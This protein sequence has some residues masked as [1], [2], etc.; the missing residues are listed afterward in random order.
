MRAS[1]ECKRGRHQ[2]A[3][4]LHHG[5]QVCSGQLAAR[6]P[7]KAGQVASHRQAQA[8]LR[9][10]S[11]QLR[12]GL[13]RSRRGN[14]HAAAC[15]GARLG[16]RS[17]AWC[18]SMHAGCAQNAAAGAHPPLAHAPLTVWRRLAAAGIQAA[19]QG[20]GG[21]HA[22]C[23]HSACMRGGQGRVGSGGGARQPVAACMPASAVWAD[24][25]HLAELLIGEGGIRPCC[26]SGRL[27][28]MTAGRRQCSAGVAWHHPCSRCVRRPPHDLR[29][30]LRPPSSGSSVVWP[31]RT[32]PCRSC[33]AWPLHTLQ[34]LT[35]RC[36][37]V[38]RLSGNLPAPPQLE[39]VCSC[40]R[41]RLRKRLGNCLWSAQGSSPG[42]SP[43]SICPRSA[44]PSRHEAVR[45]PPPAC[46]GCPGDGVRPEPAGGARAPCARPETRA[47]E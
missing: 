13:R 14:A 19:R 6:V 26:R 42:L 5:G 10:S 32:A 29:P 40:Q 27:H 39:F 22:Q 1:H 34:V 35:G 45:S 23:L 2:R 7:A 38:R 36:A 30:L 44:A 43:R 3:P 8:R 11:G 33:V 46:A 28:T 24:Q 20:R 17:V 4:H 37:A 47:R 12:L 15:S 31:F 41:G 16:R 21:I 9:V 18:S 25:A